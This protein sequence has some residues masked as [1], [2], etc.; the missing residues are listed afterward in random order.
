M[1][2]DFEYVISAVVFIFS[3]LFIYSS[4]QPYSFITGFAATPKTEQTTAELSINRYI[5]TGIDNVPVNFTYTGIVPGYWYNASNGTGIGGWPVELILYWETNCDTNTTYWGDA[6][7]C[8]EGTSCDEYYVNRFDVGNLTYNTTDWNYT[9]AGD[10]FYHYVWGFANT[11]IT[12]ASNETQVGE[13]NSVKIYNSTCPC[14][15][16]NYTERIW[17]RLYVPPGIYTGNYR[18]N[19]TFKVMD[20]GGGS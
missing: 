1:K 7:F 20:I 3:F 14:G 18:A 6:Y 2:I 10:H 9:I 13:A 19:I 5:N 8:R 17:Y 16:R 11:N 12:D 15:E 4:L